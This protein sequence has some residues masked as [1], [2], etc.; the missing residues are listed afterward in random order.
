MTIVNT[1]FDKFNS[2]PISFNCN[3]TLVINMITIH[4]C[5]SQLKSQEVKEGYLCMRHIHPILV[6]STLPLSP[7][8]YSADRH[9]LQYQSIALVLVFF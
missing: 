2:I 7:P 4:T 5:V 8:S 1:I 9:I 6:S 3:H